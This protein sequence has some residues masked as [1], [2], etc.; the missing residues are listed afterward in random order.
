MSTRAPKW[1]G[2][3]VEVDGRIGVIIYAGGPKLLVQFEDKSRVWLTRAV[4]T[5]GDDFTVLD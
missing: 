4:G 2:K 3:R 5:P 1:Q